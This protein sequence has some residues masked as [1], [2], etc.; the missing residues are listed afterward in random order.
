MCRQFSLLQP[1]GTVTTNS[2]MHSYVMFRLFQE[3]CS[4]DRSWKF[5]SVGPGKSWKIILL[6]EWSPCSLPSLPSYLPSRHP[7]LPSQLPSCLFPF[8]FPCQY[9]YP[10]NP[11]RGLG[12]AVSSSSGLGWSP[13][14]KCFWCIFRPKSAHLFQFH[15]E[16]FIIFTVHIGCVQRQRN[17]IPVGATTFWPWGQSWS[18][19]LCLHRGVLCLL[20]GCLVRWLVCCACDFSESTSPIFMKFST[21]I[22]Y[23][24]SKTL[25]TFEIGNV[26]SLNRVPSWVH[27]HEGVNVCCSQ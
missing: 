14:A 1:A 5:I 17:K 18:R 6:K 16:T 23:Q 15:N 2:G 4:V 13:A 3:K 7:S 11:A 9:A 19:R 10:V 22:Q 8:P 25:L 26:P 24:K 27:I 21:Y 12:N 20:V